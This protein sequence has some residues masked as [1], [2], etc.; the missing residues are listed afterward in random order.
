[1]LIRHNAGTISF[2][3]LPEDYHYW[4]GTENCKKQGCLGY[5]EELLNDLR[6]YKNCEFDIVSQNA[7]NCTEVFF[8]HIDYVK[9]EYPHLLSP[10]KIK[11]N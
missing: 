9:K 3:T 1:M 11:L 5:V 2:E 8:W 7:N 4:N 10:K 6:D